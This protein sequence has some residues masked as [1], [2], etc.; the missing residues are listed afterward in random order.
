MVSRAAALADPAVAEAFLD[1]GVGN[2]EVQDLIDGDA[3]G[4]QGQG[5][6]QGPGEAVQNE[7]IL[8]V[9]LG[10]PLLDDA[11]YHLV[12]DQAPLVD[13]G[14]G[15]LPQRGAGPDGLPQDDAGGDRGNVQMLLD[16]LPLGPL[17]R[18]RGS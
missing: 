14:L 5:L 1:E 17:P 11:V 2:H 10:Q 4:V 15:L 6:G 9:L 12:R 8:A 13:N 3:H 7:A 16:D 18:S